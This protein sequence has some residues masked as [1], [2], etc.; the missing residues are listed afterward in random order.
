VTDIL[1]KLLDKLREG[2]SFCPYCGGEVTCRTECPLEGLWFKKDAENLV[3]LT[4]QDCGITSG[5]VRE[6]NCPYAEEIN[7]AYV[8]IIVCPDCESER[9]MDI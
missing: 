5:D 9:A 2:Q 1:T 3:L 4:C 8:E 6:T 7:G